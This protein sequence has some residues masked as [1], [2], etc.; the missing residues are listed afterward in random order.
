MGHPRPLF[1][2]LG[3][4][5]LVR[6]GGCGRASLRLLE[7][8]SLFLGLGVVDLCSGFGLTCFAEGV[9]AKVLFGLVG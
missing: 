5:G 1:L 2:W 9:G 7:V 8:G 6:K 3:G 4:L